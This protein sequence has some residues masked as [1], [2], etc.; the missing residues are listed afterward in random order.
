MDLRAQVESIVEKIMAAVQALA[1]QLDGPPATAA[2]RL[3]PRALERQCRDLGLAVGH[4]VFVRLLQGYGTGKQGTAV[5]C[6]CGGTRRWVGMRARTLRDLMNR[7]VTL[8]RAYYYCARC[9]QGWLPLD[10][11]LGMTSAQVTPAL[12]E[13]AV[14]CGS[15]APPEEA[16][17]LLTL[18]AGIALSP[19]SIER[20]TKTVGAAVERAVDARAAGVQ[21]DTTPEP[22]PAATPPARR[23]YNLQ[24]DG[25]MLRM[26][27]GTFREV[28]LACLFDARDRA[29]LRAGRHDL[30]HKH[31]EVHL[32]SPA[33]LGQRTYAAARAYGATADGAD[34][35]SQGDGAPWVWNLVQEHWPAAW[36]V[37]DYYHLSEHLHACAQTLWGVGS[38]RA[39]SWARA[40]GEQVLAGDAAVVLAALGRLRP[41]T[42]AATQ[43]VTALRRYVQTHHHRLR[44]GALRAQGYAVASAAVES[45]IHSVVQRRLKRPGQRWT[46]LGA[47]QVLAARRLWCN[48]QSPADVVSLAT[49]RHL[50][51]PSYRRR[52]A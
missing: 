49:M 41:Q 13:V 3:D 1:N 6:G 19:K 16:A 42:P 20:Y 10:E 7:E 35:V 21:A 29:E 2:Q 25:G 48:R 33:P 50:V 45:A 46:E 8:E 32:G 36:E 40:V 17:E 9:G 22:R 34:V 39:R 43:A 23:V 12:Q 31:Y 38:E 26:R 24:L 5:G 30:L 14:S 15:V 4:E 47:R 11:T 52:A 37:L 27:D 44:Y 51:G 18:V 28:K